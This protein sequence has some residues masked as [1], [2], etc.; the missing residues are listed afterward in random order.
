MLDPCMGSGHFLVFALPI[1]VAFRRA[2]EGLDERAAVKAVL[3]ENLFGLE[4]DP[5][6]TQIAAFALALASW[7]R[8]GGPEPLPRLNLACCGLAMGLSKA[9]FLRLAEKIA[10]A[11]GW[12][13]ARTR[14]G[15]QRAPLGD[16]A[17]ARIRGGLERLHELL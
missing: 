17:A 4:I 12:A 7:K 1:L 13:G 9:E 5:R 8:L 16:R 10:D 11:E 2:E 14:L 3:A 6:C 15:T